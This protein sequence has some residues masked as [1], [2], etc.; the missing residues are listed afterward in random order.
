MSVTNKDGKIL[1]IL[2]D[3]EDHWYLGDSEQQVRDFHIKI[4]GEDFIESCKQVPIRTAKKL[5][6]WLEDEGNQVPILDL[7]NEDQIYYD[8]GVAFIASTVY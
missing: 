6:I 8:D 5:K 3:G 7:I 4:C 2:N 1:F